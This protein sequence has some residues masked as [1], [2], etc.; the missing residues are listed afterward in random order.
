MRSHGDILGA[1]H[2]SPEGVGS[3][4]GHIKGL[5]LREVTQGDKHSVAEPHVSRHLQTDESVARR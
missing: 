5:F 1:P 3:K 2:I 4:E